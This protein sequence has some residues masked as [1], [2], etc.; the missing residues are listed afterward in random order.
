MNQVEGSDAERRDDIDIDLRMGTLSLNDAEGS[1][2]VDSVSEQVPNHVSKT[3]DS[4][5]SAIRAHCNRPL[6]CFLQ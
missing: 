3:S 2:P 5:A 1:R 6:K 4:G